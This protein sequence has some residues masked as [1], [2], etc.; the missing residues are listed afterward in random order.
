MRDPTNSDD[1]DYKA[2]LLEVKYGQK[3]PQSF[4]Q[5]Q[6]VKKYFKSQ[7]EGVRVTG[8]AEATEIGRLFAALSSEVGQLSCCDKN[9]ELYSKIIGDTWDLSSC[10][11]RDMISFINSVVEKAI[12]ICGDLVCDFCVVAMGSLA[13]WE[14][15][16]YS[17]L[18]FLFLIAFR[19]DIVIE[20]FEKLAVTMYFLI[21]NLGETKLKYMA[22]PE[23]M[24]W[25]DEKKEYI[26][27]WFNDDTKN[28]VKIDGLGSWAGN[29]PT[30]GDGDIEDRNK[31][32]CT[33]DELACKYK[34]VLDHPDPKK[35]VKGDMTAL[36]SSTIPVFG[37]HRL[38]DRF[39]SLIGSYHPNAKRQNI[40]LDM[41]ASDA[42]QFQLGLGP[43]LTYTRNLKSDIYRYPSILILN[44]KILYSVSWGDPWDVIAELY[45]RGFISASVRI[46]L[47]LS[48]CCALFIRLSA[49]F[50]HDSQSENIS[51]L[52]S[53]VTENWSSD[54][55]YVSPEL[56]VHMFLYLRPL[57]T[58]IS[59][60]ITNKLLLKFPR[61][62]ID[63][64]LTYEGDAECA[65]VVSYHSGDFYQAFSILRNEFA[66]NMSATPT[67]IQHIYIDSAIQCDK[68][69]EAEN[70]LN[71]R[72]QS[73]CCDP[74]DFAYLGR[75]YS[76]KGRPHQAL[77]CYKTALSLLNEGDYQ[78]HFISIA[79]SHQD[80]GDVLFILG[81]CEEALKWL[82]KCLEMIQSHGDRPLLA[83]VL[84]NIGL[85]LHRQGLYD[86]AE[87]KCKES[88]DT[89]LRM[90]GDRE[91]IDIARC[92]FNLGLVHF[93]QSRYVESLSEYRKCLAMLARIRGENYHRAKIFIA[94]VHHN[95]SRVLVKQALY[96]EARAELEE[97]S[98]I[99]SIFG[100][101]DCVEMALVHSDTG[102]ILFRRRLFVE[103][104]LEFKKALA[105]RSRIF[106]GQDHVAIAAGH[107]DI[108]QT[109]QRQDMKTE[110]LVEYRR[111]LTMHLRISSNKENAEIVNVHYRIAEVLRN[112][113]QYKKALI[114]YRQCLA[115]RQRIFDDDDHISNAATLQGMGAALRSQ[116]LIDEAVIEYGRS[117]RIYMRVF[118]D[119]NHPVVIRV[120]NEYR[121]VY[122][123][124]VFCTIFPAILRIIVVCIL[125]YY[126]VI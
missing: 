79:R 58:A 39:R 34:S 82:R 110:A 30:G 28:G 13:R 44:L 43:K 16:P 122:R 80:I 76:C 102:N 63:V 31:F 108:G 10:V 51:V 27:H 64:E 57:Q 38:H 45:G 91:H 86:E 7:V 120:R 4:S 29:I 11:T 99:Y 75:V 33:V 22:I 107:F 42:K 83:D 97:C 112:Q 116:G 104:R 68:Y 21:G 56:L 23:L 90:F 1:W 114:E 77:D 66:S 118:K 15:T 32:I 78:H 71:E 26:A 46:S 25:N 106:D 20:Y 72:I 81:Q 70:L 50:H 40:T 94:Q 12:C 115:M 61:E 100:D 85:V 113:K 69:T 48:F 123:Y 35:A 37:D 59:R 84:M 98:A 101:T 36:L 8:G 119:S 54:A 96:T 95:I 88:L 126:G 5:R 67:A 124:S 3:S 92:L 89:F 111:S 2:Y 17:D 117:L 49:Y 18:E 93:S 47:L 41:L 53:N 103:A 9:F 19:S 62:K 24:V 6:Q 105:M 65:A 60:A 55:W 74:R 14:A 121:K 125:L 87:V 52:S 109:L 73:E